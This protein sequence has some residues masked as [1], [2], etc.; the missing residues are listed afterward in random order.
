MLKLKKK[1]IN[2]FGSFLKYSS[3][4]FL[5]YFL[6]TSL[7]Y[8]SALLEATKYKLNYFDSILP[9]QTPLPTFVL[10]VI[11]SPWN[12]LPLNHR[13]KTYKLPSM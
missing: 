12:S 11:I 8:S 4:V 6:N 3:E 5:K 10:S 13:E 9:I 1:E 7:K 2:L